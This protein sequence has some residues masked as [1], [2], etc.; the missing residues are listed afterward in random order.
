MS[1]QELTGIGHRARWIGPSLAIAG[2]ITLTACGGGT[3]AA[4]TAGTSASGSTGTASS[5]AA[6]DAFTN[7]LAQNGV[8]LPERPEGSGGPDGG[9]TPPTGTPPTGAPPAG[10]GRGAQQAPPGVDATTWEAAQ[11]ACASL[12]PTPPAG[13]PTG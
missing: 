2:V 13:V 11:K 9:M 3:T 1:P 12:A 7:C 10:A 8:T 4:P 6:N 5:P